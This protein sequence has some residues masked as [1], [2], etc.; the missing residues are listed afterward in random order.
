MAQNILQ[1]VMICAGTWF[2]WRLFRR[3]FVK[4]TLDNVPGPTSTSFL[5]GEYPI[6]LPHI[7]SPITDMYSREL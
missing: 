7:E 1:A 3:F 2:L 6:S 4:T 5:Y